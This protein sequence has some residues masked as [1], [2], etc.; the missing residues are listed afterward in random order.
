MSDSK[1]L[2]KHLIITRK[3]EQMLTLH[4]KDGDENFNKEKFAKLIAEL[5]DIYDNFFN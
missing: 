3:S 1:I 4:H 5:S 2:S